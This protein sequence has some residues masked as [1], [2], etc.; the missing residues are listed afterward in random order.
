MRPDKPR[1][2]VA[3]PENG[4]EAPYPIRLTGPV[5]KGFGR[6]SGEVGFCALLLLTALSACCG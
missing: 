2:P 5:I 6:G 1:D 3:G 4:P